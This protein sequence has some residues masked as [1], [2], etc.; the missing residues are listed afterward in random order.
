MV[1]L[2]I[3]EARSVL[4]ETID[5]VRIERQPIYLTRHRKPVAALVDVSR[6][7]ALLEAESALAQMRDESDLPTDTLER[8][9]RRRM[10]AMEASAADFSGWVTE[11]TTHPESASDIYSA[12]Q[13]SL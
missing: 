6:L 5:R 13:V 9:R 7:E 1:T 2:S 11:G 8:E 10:A 4:S 12:R 3:T